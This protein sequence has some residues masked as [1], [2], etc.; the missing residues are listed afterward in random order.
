MLANAHHLP[1]PARDLPCCA[2]HRRDETIVQRGGDPSML[3][4]ENVANETTTALAQLQR[5]KQHEAEGHQHCPGFARVTIEREY[6][7]L[8][9]SFFSF[10]GLTT[11]RKTARRVLRLQRAKGEFQNFVPVSLSPFQPHPQTYISLVPVLGPA[12]ARKWE[13]SLARSS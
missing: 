6:I 8:R 10:Q 13:L 2:A 1:T 11:D 12:V 7:H 3:H 4:R 9:C 5:C